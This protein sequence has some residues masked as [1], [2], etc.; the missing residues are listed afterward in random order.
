MIQVLICLVQTVQ[1]LTNGI[2]YIYT[3][4]C[5]SEYFIFPYFIRVNLARFTTENNGFYKTQE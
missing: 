5:V 2:L 1:I 3:Y 4:I